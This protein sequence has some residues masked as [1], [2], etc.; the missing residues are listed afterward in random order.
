MCL[1]LRSPEPQQNGR[2]DAISDPI[3]WRFPPRGDGPGLVSD[4]PETAV[5]V[6]ADPVGRRAKEPAKNYKP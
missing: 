5:Q 1:V 4:P 3:L 6:S 2:S